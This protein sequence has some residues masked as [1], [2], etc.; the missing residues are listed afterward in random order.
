MNNG[1]QCVCV[2]DAYGTLFDTDAAAVQAQDTLGKKARPLAAL[3]RAKQLQYTWLHSL[4]GRCADFWRVTGDALDYSLADL[5]I[6]DPPLRE[7]LMGLYL[8]LTAYS[9]V[10]NTLTRLRASGT[11]VAILSN[12]SPAMLEAAT[13]SA[14]IDGLLDAVISADA[15]RVFKPD[16]RA[17]QLAVDCLAVSPGRIAFVTS[18]GWDAYAAKAFGFYVVWCNRFAQGLERMPGAPDVEISNLEGLLEPGVLPP[19]PA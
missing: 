14:G 12:G 19:L 3:W 4:I 8:S 11:Q 10:K 5:R 2:F 13:R 18:N 7:R 17:Y 9:E 15:N 6:E 16:P 1:Q